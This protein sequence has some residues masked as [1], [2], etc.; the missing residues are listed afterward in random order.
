M[1]MRG[2]KNLNEEDLKELKQLFNSFIPEGSTVISKMLN[3][4]VEGKV[5]EVN[6]L[7]LTNSRQIISDMPF[8]EGCASYVK[9]TSLHPMGAL[10]LF[11]KTDTVK[12][13]NALVGKK[14]KDD[15]L[16]KSAI[17]ETGNI[18]IGNFFNKIS[19]LDGLHYTPSVPVVAYE[20]IENLIQIP[21]IDIA[22]T[23]ESDVQIIGRF[24]FQVEKNNIR[25]FMFVILDMM[26]AR[27]ILNNVKDHKLRHVVMG[28]LLVS[29]DEKKIL[30]TFVGSC[31]ALC[32]YDRVAKVG[33]LAHIMLPTRSKKHH[34]NRLPS[35]YA[36]QAVKNM[37]EI[38]LK[39]GAKVQRI[40]AN[41]AGG[42][43]LFSQ[44]NG[45]VLSV[46]TETAA[47]IKSL[48]REKKI[49]LMSEDIGKNYGRD[50]HFNI[51]SGGIS[52]KNRYVTKN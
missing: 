2:V 36:D 21:I 50:I 14:T 4:P 31:V 33:G 5:N 28:D 15:A 18:V 10:V 39:K 41:M 35:K 19:K 8:Q 22:K 29:N 26:N 11:S 42:A 32:L 38:M 34:H 16:Q 3:M 23:D 20:M 44:E 6:T 13:I 30:Q 7:Q 49:T 1:R 40:K 45:S 43:N 17:A 47:T 52:V 27:K 25:I 51:K 24:E 37:L 9:S 12:F 46:G 48:L